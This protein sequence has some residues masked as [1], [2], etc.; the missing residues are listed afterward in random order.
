MARLHFLRN[1]ARTFDFGFLGIILR[2]QSRLSINPRSDRLWTPTAIPIRTEGTTTLIAAL[3]VISILSNA[4]AKTVL[5]KAGAVFR[6]RVRPSLQTSH[7]EILDLMFPP[8]GPASTVV[9]LSSGP[10]RVGR[11]INQHD[12]VRNRR[13]GV[14]SRKKN[15][16]RWNRKTALLWLTKTMPGA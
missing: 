6:S 8:R 13:R 2:K 9:P 1:P 3:E 11:P 5:M 10:P 15:A 16:K 14:S 4:P 12:T 7:L